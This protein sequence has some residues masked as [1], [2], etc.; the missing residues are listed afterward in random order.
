L[1]KEKYGERT[2][3]IWIGESEAI[4]IALSLEG[5]KP[6][7]PLTHDLLKL[8]IDSFQGRVTKIEIVDFKHD[9]YFAKIYLESDGKLIGIDARPSDSIALALRTHSS[10]FVKDDIMSAQG[11]VFEGDKSVDELKRHLRNIKPEDFGT[12]NL[13]QPLID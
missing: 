3:P 6:P 10:L 8:V 4:A 9:T 11:I 1:L 2:L 5:F 12:F 13:K 7:R